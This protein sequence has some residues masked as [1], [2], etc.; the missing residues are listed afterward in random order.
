MDEREPVERA[1]PEPEDD[2]AAEIRYSLTALGE[3]V[4]A[5]RRGK[6]FRGF[7]PCA[8]VA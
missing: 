6:R 4:L 5:E 7:G 1:A 2:E 3:A 8:A